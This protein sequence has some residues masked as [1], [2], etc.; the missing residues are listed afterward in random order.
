MGGV[1]SG[2]AVLFSPTM[3]L[4]GF[5]AVAVIAWVRRARALASVLALFA[6]FPLVTIV[7]AVSWPLIAVLAVGV[8]VVVRFRWSR[9]SSIVS[10]WGARSRRKS[11]VAS[12]LDVFRFAGSAAMLRRAGTVRPSL[13]GASRRE[14]VALPVSEVAVRL[15]RSGPQWVWSSVEDVVVSVGGPRSGKSGWLAGQIID[16]P[17]AVLATST[18]LDLREICTAYRERKGPVFVFN[19]AGLGGVSSSVTFDPLTGCEDPVGAVERAADLLSAVSSRGGRGG[20]R[21]Y[22]ELQG[23]RVLEALLHAAALGHRSMREVLDWTANPESAHKEVTGLLRRSPEPAFGVSFEQFVTTND[24]TRTSI[25]ST[26]MPTLG[27]SHPLRPARPRASA[28]A[29]PDPWPWRTCWCPGARCSCSV[30]RS[31]RP[32]RW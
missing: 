23:R 10:R 9:S 31:P 25:T 3:L 32:R 16:A 15:C 27:C 5:A 6:L 21:D 19:P 26:I 2:F 13:E 29:A 30:A 14:L 17:G 12:T 8:L 1:M 20:D 24:R 4:L 7:R 11:G 22:W 18:R 28:R